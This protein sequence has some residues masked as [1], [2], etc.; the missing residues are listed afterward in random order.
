MEI[1]DIK[2]NIQD[3]LEGARL[4]A[5]DEGINKN[6]HR[7]VPFSHPNDSEQPLTQKKISIHHG[8]RPPTREKKCEEVQNKAPAWIL[9]PSETPYHTFN[10][11]TIGFT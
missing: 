3:I 9:S 10:L 5:T 8:Y 11:K 7:I 6:T 2:G 1:K 4:K